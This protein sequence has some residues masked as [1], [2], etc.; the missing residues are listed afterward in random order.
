MLNEMICS[1]YHKERQQLLSEDGVSALFNA[2]DMN[3]EFKGSASLAQT[4][5]KKLIENKTLQN[6]VFGPLSLVVICDDEQDLKNALQALHGQL[7]GTVL[8]TSK[9][10]GQYQNCIDILV[11]KVGRIIYNG[12]PTGVEVCHSMMHGGPFPATTY[13]HFTSVGSEAIKRFLRPV[14]YQDCPQEFLP[15]VLKD[16]N[17]LSIMRKLNGSFTKSSIHQLEEINQ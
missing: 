6:E 3:N 2:D 5:A 16:E 17:P 15:D 4:S 10:I 1:A 8:G 14:C 11:Q 9:D 13:A 7:T 12:V